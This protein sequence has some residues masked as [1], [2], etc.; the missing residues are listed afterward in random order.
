MKI[1]IKNKIWIVNPHYVSRMIRNELHEA[2]PGMFEC[3][4]DNEAYPMEWVMKVMQKT[5]T[6]ILPLSPFQ[7]NVWQTVI[8]IKKQC[9]VSIFFNYHNSYPK[10]QWIF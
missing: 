3:D 6:T 4:T 7:Y 1:L 5:G 8:L 10:L 9:F 2:L